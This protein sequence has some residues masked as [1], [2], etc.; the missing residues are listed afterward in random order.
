MFDELFE[1]PHALM[2]QRT[3]PLVEE[4]VRYLRHLADEGMSRRTLRVAAIFLL[5]VCER[6]DLGDRAGEVIDETEV[7]EAAAAWAV[8]PTRS[9]RE[10]RSGRRRFR[11]HATEWLRFMG[12]LHEASKPLAPCADL[13]AEYA[14]YMAGERGLSP[15]TIAYRCVAIEDF[16]RRVAATRDSL[17]EIT[18]TQIDRVLVEKV[19]KG[20]YARVTVQTYAS[21]LRSFLR[22]AETRGWSPSGHA[23]AIKSPRVFPLERLPVGPSW[24]EVRRLLASTEGDA[25]TDIR[26][27]AILFLLSVY[28]LRNGE[29]MHLRLEDFDWDQSLLLVRRDKTCSAQRYPLTRPV[30]DAVLRYL[31]QVRPRSVHPEVFLTMRAPFRPLRS[32]L[33][34]IVARR[35]RPLG[36]SIPH[37]GPHALR[38]AC[39]TRLLAQG[40]SLKEIGDHLGHRQPDT[41]RI[42]AKV[43]L[44][45]LRRVGDFDLGGLL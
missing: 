32:G 15:H 42:Y 19:T 21:T 13:V 38:H 17:R 10:G 45:G 43:D 26:D 34:R 8:R 18:L 39:A 5:V 28:G 6:L 44:A 1:R 37:H 33:W 29:V 25:P 16:L 20:G 41:T 7:E 9:R 30:G 14:K 4:R 40:L 36:V 11:Q 3:A 24:A 22:F 12:R 23:M 31:R 27:R 2:R 35:L